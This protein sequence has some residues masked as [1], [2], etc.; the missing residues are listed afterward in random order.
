[1]NLSKN[2]LEIHQLR[3]LT[4]ELSLLKSLETNPLEAV[5]FGDHHISFQAPQKT[6]FF[7]QLVNI[8]GILHFKK[9]QLEFFASGKVCQCVAVGEQQC[10]YTIEMHRYDKKVWNDFKQAIV[11]TQNEVD[12]L[13]YSMRDLD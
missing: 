4:T 9:N 10:K 7:G 2:H 12:K 6:C 8:E 1:M 5:E 11:D 3:N 13:F